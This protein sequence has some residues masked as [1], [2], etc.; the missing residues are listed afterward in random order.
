MAAEIPSWA[1][2]TG[3]ILVAADVQLP[4][5]VFENAKARAADDSGHSNT[6]LVSGTEQAL[7]KL[8]VSERA[9]MGGPFT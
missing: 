9:A 3:D 2:R 7:L 4:L 5:V 1:K 6:S 8:T